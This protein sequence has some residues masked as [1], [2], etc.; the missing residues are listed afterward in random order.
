VL[1][2]TRAE[3][4]ER[5]IAADHVRIA[6][7]AWEDPDVTDA[8]RHLAVLGCGSVL[9]VPACFPFDVLDTLVDLPRAAALARAD[10]GVSVTIQSG[11]GDEAEFAEWVSARVAERMQSEQTT[12]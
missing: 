9:V 6:W 4:V 5:G 2:R 7:Q 11:L 12:T 3:L 8:V 1:Q 10:E